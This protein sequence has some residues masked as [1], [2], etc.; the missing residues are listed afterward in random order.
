MGE[1]IAEIYGVPE[2]FADAVAGAYMAGGVIRMCFWSWQTPPGGE[3]QK[4][5]SGRLLITR[6]GLIASRPLVSK[7]LGATELGL[8]MDVQG[9]SRGI[10]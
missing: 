6:E 10:H 2:I 4:V 3:P 9:A 8:M 1:D 5:M 7:V